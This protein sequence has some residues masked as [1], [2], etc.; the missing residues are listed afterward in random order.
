MSKEYTT[1][2]IHSQSQLNAAAPLAFFSAATAAAAV[3]GAAA[4]AVATSLAL[5]DD[6]CPSKMKTLPPIR[7][8]NS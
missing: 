4:G 2:T 5:G 7:C 8:K 6:N 3:V 1:P